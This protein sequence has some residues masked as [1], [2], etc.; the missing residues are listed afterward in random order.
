MKKLL[1]I[2]SIVLLLFVNAS[3]DLDTFVGSESIDTFVGS[4]SIDEAV[5]V[6]IASGAACVTIEQSQTDTDNDNTQCGFSASQTYT[7]GRFDVGGTGYD[8]CK[9]DLYLKKIVGDSTPT[10]AFTA[11]LRANNVDEPSASVIATSTTSYG[12]GDLTTGH[13]PYVFE[14]ASSHTL[15]ASTSYWLVIKF[16][17]LGDFGDYVI[18]GADSDTYTD[19]EESEDGTTWSDETAA[20]QGYRIYK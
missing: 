19:Q 6:P 7:A 13:L 4:E 20:H 11:E 14:F 15:S 16:T 2:I 9:F 1:L 18:W 3:A 8:L 5:G 12:P 17:T 10:Y